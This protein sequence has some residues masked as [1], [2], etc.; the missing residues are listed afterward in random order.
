MSRRKV[1][2]LQPAG[3]TAKGA[4]TNHISPRENKNTLHD[5]GAKEALSFI[6]TAQLDSTAR[7]IQLS[8]A[9]K[10]Q[11]GETSALHPQFVSLRWGS[12]TGGDR[13]RRLFPSEHCT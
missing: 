5:R 7:K 11:L 1:I 10:T 3:G 2:G 9:L 12:V 6:N 13:C 4:A 8:P